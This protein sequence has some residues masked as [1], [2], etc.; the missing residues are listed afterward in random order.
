MSTVCPICKSVIEAEAEEQPFRP[1]CSQRCK[2][3]DLSNW[4]SESYTVAGEPET[5]DPSNDPGSHTL[6]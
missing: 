4:L 5:P 2:L 6:H 1:F 3:A